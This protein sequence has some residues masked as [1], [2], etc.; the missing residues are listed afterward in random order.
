MFVVPKKRPN[1]ADSKYSEIA[2]KLLNELM[3]AQ[4]DQK[5]K[6]PLKPKSNDIQIATLVD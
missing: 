3:K 2:N 1:L 5:S 4:A 6:A